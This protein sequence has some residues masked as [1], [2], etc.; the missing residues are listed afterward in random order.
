[1]SVR[2]VRM[3]HREPAN[4]S[5]REPNG[6]VFIV[7]VMFLLIG[8]LAGSLLERHWDWVQEQWVTAMGWFE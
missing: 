2:P 6:A 4:D 1:M 7:G 5:R 3:P 8:L